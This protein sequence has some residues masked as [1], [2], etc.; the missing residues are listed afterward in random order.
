[1][2]ISVKEGDQ[3]S[4]DFIPNAERHLYDI[5]GDGVAIKD[6]IM[7]NDET[8]EVERFVRDEIGELIVEGDVIKTEILTFEDL[9]IVKRDELTI[10]KRVPHTQTGRS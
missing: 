2:R 1:M 3:D 6:V 8:G 4:P 7:A 5:Y 10:V 9:K